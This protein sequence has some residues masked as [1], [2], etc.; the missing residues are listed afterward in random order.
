MYEIV[1]I[2]I[3]IC[4]Y[5][6]HAHFL[7]R[8]CMQFS[9]HPPL[10][11]RSVDN[12]LSLLPTSFVFDHVSFSFLF[13]FA[14]PALFQELDLGDNELSRLPTSLQRL[15]SLSRLAL[16]YSETHTPLLE[17]RLPHPNDQPRSLDSPLIAVRHTHRPLITV[18]HTHRPLITVTHTHRLLI[19]VRN[20]HRPLIIVWLAHPHGWFWFLDSPLITVRHTRRPLTIVRLTQPNCRLRSLILPL[21]IVR[22]T[23]P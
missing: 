13:S 10:W 7:F 21:M 3:Y 12:Q 17:F 6:S 14:F 8:R 15:T 20:A 11:I 4:I 2:Y 19:T 16:N 9:P 5:A 18:R 22:H 1:C 23:H